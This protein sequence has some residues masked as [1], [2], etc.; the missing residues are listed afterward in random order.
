MMEAVISDFVKVERMPGFS[1]KL[2]GDCCRNRAIMLYDE[3][4]RR[5]ESSGFS[6]FYEEASELER[7]LTGAPYRMRLKEDG[8][9]V[10]LNDNRCSVYEFRPD[11]CRRYPF[12]V[13]DGFILASLSCPGIDWG[14]EGDPERFRGPSRRMAEAIA[15]F[16]R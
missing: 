7:Y 13:G 11:T 4:V 1:C 9:C 10:F 5:L 14:G 16:V 12:I 2:C 3:D 8:S 6:E 15:R